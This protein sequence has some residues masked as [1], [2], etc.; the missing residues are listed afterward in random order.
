[1][2]VLVFALVTGFLFMAEQTHA[3]DQDAEETLRAWADAYDARDG[4]KS[5]AVYAQDARL[6]GTVSQK[7]TVGRDA[8]RGYF[9]AGKTLTARHVEIGEHACRAFETVAVCSGHYTFQRTP[10]EGA[11]QNDPA[12][13]SMT[14]VKRDGRWEIADHHSS[15]LPAQR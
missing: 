6:W 12:R 2:R 1:M 7:Q 8:I 10:Q 15:L 3:T 14:I 9:D 11:A 4:E 5:A 13:F